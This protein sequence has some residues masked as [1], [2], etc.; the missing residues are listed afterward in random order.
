MR[1]SSTTIDH[2]PASVVRP[3]Y[4]R[5]GQGRGIVHLGIGA[6]HRAHQAIYTDEAMAGGDRNWAIT[7]V[8]LRA[9]R[10]RDALAP[11]D[12]L[13]TVT[14]RGADGERTRLIG[15]VAEVLVAQESPSAVAAALAAPETR[16]VTLTV[17]EKGYHRHPD[18]TLDL[19]AV[20]DATDTIYQHLTRAFVQRRDAGLPGLTLLSCDNLAD[21]GHALTQALTAYIDHT[22]PTLRSWF[23]AECTCPSTMVDR[24]VPAV[25]ETDLSDIAGR[26]GL[27]DE[28]AV[29]TEPF[30]QW[31]IEDRFVG[32]RPKWESVGVQLVADVKPYETAKLRLLNG[33]HSALAYLGLAAGHRYVYQAIADPAIRPLIEQLM[34]REA[35]VS[36]RAAPGQNLD[37]YTDALLKRFGNTSLPHRLLQI[38]TDGSQKIGPRWLEPLAINRAQGIACPAIL[39]A[40]AAWILFVRGESQPVDDPMA[41]TLARCW[42]SAG[43]PAIV[44]ALFGNGGMMNRDRPLGDADLQTLKDYVASGAILNAAA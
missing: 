21:N 27:R 5:A 33:A 2:L 24:I 39:R 3:G 43:E 32:P 22:Q 38:A 34:R 44:D 16:I 29:I 31:V 41:A 26:L 20:T 35:A 14:E 11:Q 18:G 1:L 13:Y 7:G 30:R 25:T 15:S 42:Q 40:L 10:I 12:G 17:T 37:A 8:S 9:P 19:D 23:D 4:D 28:G 36:I 6:F